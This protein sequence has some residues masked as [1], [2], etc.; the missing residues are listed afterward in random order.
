MGGYHGGKSLQER[1]NEK[2]EPGENGCWNWRFP[3]SLG[4]ANTFSL[5]GKVMRAYRASFIIHG[6]EIGDGQIVCHRCDNP[7]CVNP[8]HLWLGTHI[9]NYRD[10]EGKGRLRIAKGAQKPNTKLTAES[11]RNIRKR[12]AEGGRGTL[13]LLSREFGVNKSTLQDILR[14]KTWRHVS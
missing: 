10:A 8:Q 13:A 6:G 5:N 11:V 3:N 1:F 14:G 2:W 7:L 4:R 12:H 9:D